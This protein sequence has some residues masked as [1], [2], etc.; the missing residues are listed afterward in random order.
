MPKQI[1]IYGLPLDVKRVAAVLGIAE[2]DVDTFQVEEDR[3][4][5]KVK[6]PLTP[7]QEQKLAKLLEPYKLLK[8]GEE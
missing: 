7:Q 6:V 5:V 1:Y 3:T 4:I 2:Q 8:K